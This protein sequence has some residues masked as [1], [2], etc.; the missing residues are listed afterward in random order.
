M[1]GQWRWQRVGAHTSALVH[2]GVS[3]A[4]IW[5]PMHYGFS[6][7]REFHGAFFF[8]HADINTFALCSGT[9][10]LYCTQTPW[11]INILNILLP[12]N[13]SNVTADLLANPCVTIRRCE[14]LHTWQPHIN[15]HMEVRPGMGGRGPR[16]HAPHTHIPVWCDLT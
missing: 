8:Q 15:C 14:S 4:Y 13:H 10:S 7:H 12:S 16:I 1:K 11:S 5:V 2:F 6:N 3:V 9:V